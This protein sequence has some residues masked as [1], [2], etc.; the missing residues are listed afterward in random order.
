MKKSILLSL[1]LCSIVFISHA[2]ATEKS[3]SMN[4]N[5]MNPDIIER[6]I[7]IE[8]TQKS[9]IKEMQIRND[10][11]LS[12][13]RTRTDAILNEMR[14]KNDAIL[15][16]MRTR[17]IA[18]DERFKAVDQRFEDIDK[19]FGDMDKRFGDIDKRFELVQAQI[20]QQSSFFYAILAAFVAMFASILGFAVWDRKTNLA[21]AKE[22]AIQAVEAREI[23]Q[24]S[25]SLD[26]Y[27]LVQKVVDVM[28]QMTEQLP[29]MRA[30]MRTAHLL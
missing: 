4:K 24:S 22:V 20:S 26:A 25:Y 27:V 9:I 7:R 16:E 8:E 11:I 12:E 29:E 28:R 17:F 19:R 5:K 14:T 1:L 15:N 21:K 30:Y 6:L 3:E 23:K 13:M 10:A 2:W 18:V